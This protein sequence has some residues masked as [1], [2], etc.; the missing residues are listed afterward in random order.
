MHILIEKGHIIDPSQG[1]DGIG[2]ILIEDGKI[3]EILIIS[4]EQRAKRPP[5]MWLPR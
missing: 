5:E 3:K 1:I 2:N 4:D